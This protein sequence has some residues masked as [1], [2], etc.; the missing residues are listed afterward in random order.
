[1]RRMSVRA[2]A[3]IAGVLALVAGLPAAAE[4][5]IASAGPCA[6]AP[7]DACGDGA[8]SSRSAKLRSR[9]SPAEVASA[10]GADGGTSPAPPEFSGPG[11]C[12]EPGAGCGD[13]STRS[14]AAAIPQAPSPGQS[15]VGPIPPAV[16]PPPSGGV[17]NPPSPP[18]PPSSGTPPPAPP[19]PNPGDTAGGPPSAP[20]PAPPPPVAPPPPPPPPAPTVPSSPATAPPPPPPLASADPPAPPPPPP[21]VVE[22]PPAPVLPPGVPVP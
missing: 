19:A 20:S 4:L 2:A 3:P 6:V 17:P 15:G 13:P 10:P 14:L 16:A 11:S 8:C 12:A 22:P 21:G 1:V 7:R 5:D 18:L 9:F